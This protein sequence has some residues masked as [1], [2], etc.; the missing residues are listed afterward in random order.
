MIQQQLGVFINR[1]TNP[2]QQYYRACKLHISMQKNAQ[3]ITNS[4]LARI[5][6]K[7]IIQNKNTWAGLLGYK[8][9]HW[10]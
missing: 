7:Y 4:G 9:P 10:T 6:K 8:G 2:H 5:K 1:G 3:Y